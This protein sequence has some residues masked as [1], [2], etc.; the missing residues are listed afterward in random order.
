[1]SDEAPPTSPADP[2]PP[3]GPGPSPTPGLPPS[4]LPSPA[5][6]S[7]RGWE[8]ACHLAGF[9]GYLT[10]VGWILGPMIVWLLK[11]SES[12]SVDAHGREAVNFQLSVL[13]YAVTLFALGFLTCGSTFFL[14]IPL[15]IAQIILMII[16]G[17]KAADGELYRY[18]LTLRLIT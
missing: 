12:P 14:L 2:L 18:P 13:I 17:F 4:G 1:M 16:A 5:P 10:G 15:G 3:S 8:V 9:S 11:R 6:G 7:T